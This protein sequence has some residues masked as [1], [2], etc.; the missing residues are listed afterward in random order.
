MANGIQLRVEN[1]EVNRTLDSV[2]RASE[3]PAGIMAAV[4]ASMLQAMRRHFERET[5][6]DGPWQ[7]LSPRTADKRIGKRRR[8]YE[9]ML[10]VSGR[11]YSSLIQESG[12]D[13]ALVGSNLPYAA[14]HQEGGTVKMPARDQEIYQNYDAKRDS[15]DPR[16]RRRANS[17]FARTVKVGAHTITVPAR[18]YLYLDEADRAEIEAV[19]TD[20]LRDEADLR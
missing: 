16:F 1:A 4:A 19:A 5:G 9:N 10:R 6:P 18:P 3:N 12:T 17:N 8:G 14:I 7:R 2:S 13:Y 20:A 15:F 11:L